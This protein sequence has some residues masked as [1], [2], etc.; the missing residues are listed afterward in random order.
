MWGGWELKGD[1]C[2]WEGDKCGFGEDGREVSV[3]VGKMGELK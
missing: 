3:D 2:G 1:R